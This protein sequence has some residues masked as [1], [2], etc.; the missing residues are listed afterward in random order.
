MTS[1]HRSL[2][3]LA[4]PLTLAACG[5]KKDA[6]GAGKAAGSSA[7]TP[8]GGSAAATGS[9]AAPGSAAAGSAAAPGSA[10]GSAAAG[11]AAAPAPTAPAIKVDD[12]LMAALRAEATACEIDPKA[13][14]I[15]CPAGED[16]KVKDGLLGHDGKKPVDAIATLAVALADPDPKLA[17]VAADALG[18]SR[19]SGA[20]GE[21]VAVGAVG[22]DVA[23]LLLSAVEKLPALGPYQARRVIGPVVIAASLADLDSEAWAMLERNGD[24]YVKAGGW[25]AS[26]LYGR[27]EPFAKLEAMARDNAPEPT[28]LAA[29]ALASFYDLTDDERTTLCPWALSKVAV[30][31]AG[32]EAEIFGQ[33]G[34]ILSRCK[35]TWIDQLLDFGEAQRAKKVFDRQ[36][37]FVFRELCHDFFK[38]QTTDRAT[39]EQCERNFKFL[40][41]VANTDGIAAADRARALDAIS[42]Q[43]RDATSLK[44]MQKYKGSKVKEI[45]EAAQAAIKMLEGYV[46]KP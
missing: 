10:P 33:A 42:Y 24:P 23:R 13:F 9:A 34:A 5:K 8:T 17:T 2:L 29:T 36:Y 27:L 43:R 4:I 32:Q 6:D 28:L 21:G 3:L 1:V 22:K 39:T 15:K 18:S 41:K 12:E 20:W 46:K 7:T 14:S 40:E 26:T 16:A 45:A 37:Y 38:G 25:K 35:G 11:S 44:L 31:P 30:D 19:F